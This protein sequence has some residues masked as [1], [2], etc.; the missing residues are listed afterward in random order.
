MHDLI[1]EAIVV[2]EACQVAVIIDKLPPSWNDFK[3]YLKHKR[4]KMKCGY[5]VICLKIEKDNKTA[6]YKSRKSSTIIEDN[7]VKEDHT[8]GKKR[9]KFNGQKSEEAKKKFKDNC[10]N[11]GNK[12]SDCRSPRKS[13]DKV[14]SQEIIIEEM[15]HEYYLFAMIPK[16]NLVKNLKE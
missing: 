10:G 4:K 14:K 6:K 15:E 3:N 2:N 16:C 8:K 11:V 9:K 13:K 12:Y 7:I 1:I 5:L